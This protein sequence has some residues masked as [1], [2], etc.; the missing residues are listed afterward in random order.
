MH[1]KEKKKTK[2]LASSKHM[3]LIVIPV[4]CENVYSHSE[5][6]F[7]SDRDLPLKFFSLLFFFFF[8]FA[9]LPNTVILLI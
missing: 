3:R 5:N 2:C 7:S 8:F 6:A 9:S 4:I 1:I